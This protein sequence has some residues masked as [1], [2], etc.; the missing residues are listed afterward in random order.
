[1]TAHYRNFGL[2]LCLACRKTSFHRVGTRK[3]ETQVSIMDVVQCAK[4]TTP[5]EISR[6]PLSLQHTCI[7][8]IYHKIRNHG[9]DFR[10]KY[11]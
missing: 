1:M 11:N 3:E 2:V 5:Y 6:G 7:G 9:Y 4:N 10:N 8:P